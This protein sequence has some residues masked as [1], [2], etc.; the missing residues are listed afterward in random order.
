MN[1]RTMGMNLTD[2]VTSF[3]N[4]GDSEIHLLIGADVAGKLLNGEIHNLNSGPVVDGIH[5]GWTLVRKIPQIIQ[6]SESCLSIIS[7]FTR[8]INLPDLWSLDRIGIMESVESKTE[9][10]LHQAAYEHF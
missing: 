4:E 8:D 5:L 6:T 9:V 3:H 7:L 1:D 10:E 2:V